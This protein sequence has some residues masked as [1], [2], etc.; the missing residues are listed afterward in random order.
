MRILFLTIGL[1]F[2][3]SCGGIPLPVQ[4]QVKAAS[5]IGCAAMQTASCFD[6]TNVQAAFPGIN[7]DTCSERFEF[8]F[9]TVMYF[10]SPPKVPTK[11]ELA[12]VALDVI[13]L[14]AVNPSKIIGL[15]NAKCT[16]IKK[17]IGVK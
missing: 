10:T 6:D 13:A 2:M 8:L 3:V 7:A 16:Q 15:K 14:D 17:L 5:G 4:S 11:E 1:F 9:D 12:L